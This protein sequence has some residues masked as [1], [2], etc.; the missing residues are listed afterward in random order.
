MDPRRR[1]P[2]LAN[3]A[4][5]RFAANITPTPPPSAPT[6]T[7]STTTLEAS[8]SNYGSSAV[9]SASANTTTTSTTVSKKV[10]TKPLFCVVCASNQV[11]SK[12]IR[13]KVH[14]SNT[15]DIESFNGG[16]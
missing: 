9:S 10:K 7:T 13:F 14:Y 4:D 6:A 15:Y 1:D 2:R 5:P 16:S 12:W 8:S 3:R 11:R